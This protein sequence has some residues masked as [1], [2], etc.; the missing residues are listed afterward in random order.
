M[1]VFYVERLSSNGNK[2]RIIVSALLRSL[3]S[4]NVILKINVALSMCLSRIILILS[5]LAIFDTKE[6][7]YQNCSLTKWF[8][9]KIFGKKTVSK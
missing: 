9:G 7:G 3:F 8:A 6:D 1:T 4:E 2:F 5:L